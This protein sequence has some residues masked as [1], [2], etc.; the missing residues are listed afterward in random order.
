[1]INEINFK[2]RLYQETILHS[3]LKNNTLVVLPTG[4][5]KT[6]IAILAIVN[7]MKNYP[8]S[9]AL[10]LTPTKPLANQIY[11]EIKESINEKTPQQERLD[12]DFQLSRAVELIKG[13][14]IYRESLIQ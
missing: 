1:M 7:R 11:N 8:S 9:K 13:L 12:T 6:K 10:F 2:P 5:G 14:D 4:M 3:C